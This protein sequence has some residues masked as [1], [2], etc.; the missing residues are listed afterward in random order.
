MTKRYKK[1]KH[2]QGNKFKDE[3]FKT[4]AAD[5]HKHTENVSIFTNRFIYS[6]TYSLGTSEAFLAKNAKGRKQLEN[7]IRDLLLVES[8]LKT[9]IIY[10]SYQLMLHISKN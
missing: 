3:F 10:F 8:S 6:L 9:T 5:L 1:R 7:K 4:V 2:L